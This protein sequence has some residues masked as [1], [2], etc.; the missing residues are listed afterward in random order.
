[1]STTPRIPVIGLCGGIGAGKSAVAGIL[2]DLGCVV[3]DSDRDAREV[4]ADPEVLEVLRGWWGDDV[5]G[6]DGRLDR[7][8]IA[9]RV[10]G[11]DSERARLEGLVHPRLHRLREAR[12][13]AAAADTRALVIDAPLLFE[14]ELD[15]QCDAVLFIDAPLRR[16]VDRVVGGRGWDEAELHRRERAQIPLDEKR[17]RATHVIENH[18]TAME[19]EAGVRTVLDRILED[20]LEDG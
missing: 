14:A 16:R 13:R 19:L 18:G 20:S 3:S 1:M 12:F 10:F 11:D 15:A 2:A 4:L 8:R 7:S 6:T 17:S 5:V 9:G